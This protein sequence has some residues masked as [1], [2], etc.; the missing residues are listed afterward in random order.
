M[1][2]RRKRPRT[3]S[4]SRSFL[5]GF[6]SLLL[7]QGIQLWQLRVDRLRLIGIAIA[8]VLAARVKAIKHRV[9]IRVLEIL[10]WNCHPMLIDVDPV[11][12]GEVVV[13]M[14]LREIRVVRIKR[15][16]AV[17]TSLAC[18]A[19][20]AERAAAVAG[21]QARIAGETRSTR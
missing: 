12:R 11:I 21:S 17:S 1:P 20:L 9:R 4:R 5:I 14:A 3:V 8:S 10:T 19:R 15:A 13:A 16:G 6:D 18:A 7:Q 2:A